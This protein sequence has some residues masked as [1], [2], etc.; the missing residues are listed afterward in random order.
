MGT[1]FDEIIDIALVIIRDYKIDWIY[2]KDMSILHE[3]MYGFLIRAVYDFHDCLKSLDYD[4]NSRSFFLI[5]SNV[6][7]VILSDYLVY[8]WFKSLTNDTRYV[9]LHLNDSDFKH[10]AE[11]NNLKEKSE[12]L[13]RMKEKIAK[14]ITEYKLDNLDSLPYY[15]DLVK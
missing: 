5:L 13:D 12:Y 11:S 14:D 9:N 10:Y 3:Y 15:K 7:K 2:N 8:E 1:S 4:S 6:E